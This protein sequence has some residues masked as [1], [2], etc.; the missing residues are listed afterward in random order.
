MTPSTASDQGAGAAQHAPTAAEPEARVQRGAAIVPGLYRLAGIYGVNAYLWLPQAGPSQANETI[1]FDCGW[2]WSGRDLVTS[3]AGLGCRPR[4]IGALAITH[5]DF[6]HV[7]QAAPLAAEGSA[8]ILAHEFEAPRLASGRWRALPGSVTSLDPVIL[9]ASP[10]Y[11]LYP[12]RPVKVARLLR[13]GDEVGAGWVV[14]HTPGHTPGHAAF[15]HPGLRVLIA[16]DALGSVRHEQVRLPKRVYAE[17]WP[18]ALRSVEKL[19]ALEPDV[20]CFG[21]G[22]ELRGASGL[23]RS[24]ARTLPAAEI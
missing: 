18:A 15:Y 10:L 13:D 19:A 4:D 11:R 17:D 16:G 8:A 5:A 14:V 24:L 20:I 1:L 22:P 23:L 2:P 9:A 3:L 12:A 6:D 7:G 21:H